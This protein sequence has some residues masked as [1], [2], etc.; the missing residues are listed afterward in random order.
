MACTKIAV[1]PGS[2]DPVTNG[3]IDLITRG[4]KVFDELIVAVACNH[5]KKTLFTVCERMEMIEEIFCDNPQ[6]KVSTFDGLL[7]NYV[8][9]VN[10][11]AIIRGLRAVS[12]F[13]Y[14]FQMALMN[15]NLAPSVETFFMM[16]KDTYMYVSSR[17]VKEL[18]SLGGTVSN[19]VHPLVEERVREKYP[20]V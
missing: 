9:E 7:I 15:R 18:A 11:H 3:H 13:E 5:E 4:A 12:D 19:L 20:L 14:E 1:Y 16:S 2:F 8:Q 17:I 6:I 10:A